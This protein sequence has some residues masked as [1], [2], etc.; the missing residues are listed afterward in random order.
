[1]LFEVT[2][3]F[4][5]YYFR[6]SCKQTGNYTENRFWCSW[7]FHQSQFTMYTEILLYMI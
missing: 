1:M 5:S 4:Y 2:L 6:N 3:Y 7:W